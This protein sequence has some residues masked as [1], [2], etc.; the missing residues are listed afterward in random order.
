MG[1]IKE[2]NIKN[3]TYYFYNDIIDIE[4]FDSN[5]LKLNKKTYKNLHIYNIGYVT[6]KKIGY[7]YDIN[8]ANPLYL[9]INNG[10]GYIKKK[11]LK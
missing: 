9:R 8:S 7:G 5:M 11:R 4:T 6:I 2:L 3:Q 1:T 10:N